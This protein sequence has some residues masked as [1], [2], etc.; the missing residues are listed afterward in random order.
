MLLLIVEKMNDEERRNVSIPESVTINGITYVVRDTPELQK[1]M[2]AVSKVE[3]NKLYSQFESLKNQLEDLRKVQVVPDSQGSG[4]GVNVKEIV[5]A[6]RGTFVTREDLETSL[7]NTVSEVISPVIQNSEEQ[8]KQELEAY[9]NSI[10]QAHINE[11]I[12][13]LVEGNSKQELDASLEKSIQLRSKYPSPSSAAVLH[14][15]RPVVDPLIAE[16]MRKENEA[17]AQAASPTPSPVPAASPTPSPVPAA[18]PAPAVPRREAPEV[19]GPTSVKNM[20][21]SEFAARREQLE[22][23]LRATYGGV[24][25]TQL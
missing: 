12:P 23:E 19:S 6:L 14:S 7:K 9:R 3:K 8:R 5:E 10:I 25:P 21:M 18:A 13:E 4:S 15:E 24:G 20:P 11:C 16:Q 2:Q 17:R 1:F 22:A